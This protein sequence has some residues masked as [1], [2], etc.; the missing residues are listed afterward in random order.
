MSIPHGK[1]SLIT[2][3]KYILASNPNISVLSGGFAPRTVYTS[4]FCTFQSPPEAV[5]VCKSTQAS[6]HG[7]SS[8]TQSVPALGQ[9]LW[10]P[11]NFLY[12]CPPFSCA[13]VLHTSLSPSSLPDQFVQLLISISS[14][15]LI[16]DS[17]YYLR[18]SKLS[19]PVL[20]NHCA[21]CVGIREQD[22]F[23]NT[24]LIK[25]TDLLLQ[26]LLAKRL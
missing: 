25:G 19:L 10:C 21:M 7:D 5:H 18:K 14:F 12:P 22:G 15:N 13:E 2:S 24:R 4:Y 23:I 16:S 26:W 20:M 1:R 8:G 6:R 9:F 11:W 3:E 17:F